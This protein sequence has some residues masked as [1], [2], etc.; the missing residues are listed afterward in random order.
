MTQKFIPILFSTE[1]VNAILEGR[2]TQTRRVVKFDNYPPK[3]T[4]KHHSKKTVKG[5][6]VYDGNNE[7][8][9]NLIFRHGNV[10]DILWV[11]ESFYTAS[12]YNHWNPR[13]LINCNVEIFYKA[14]IQNSSIKQPLNRGKKRPSIHMPKEAC[15]IFL[16]V[17]NVRVERLNDIS[18]ID[19]IDEGV[20]FVHGVS[21][22]IYYNYESLEFGCTPKESFL[23]LW[24]KINGNESLNSNPFVWVIEF[25]KIDKP[26]NFI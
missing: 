12:N 13:L 9:G 11:R 3:L 6:E 22:K 8:D 17:T 4:H 10:G 24:K 25:E 7:L 26:Q 14:D 2:K 20:D 23:T 1:M 16:K 5:F 21:T 18:R 15:R 19:A